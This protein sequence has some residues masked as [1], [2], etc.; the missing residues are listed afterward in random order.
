M[1]TETETDLICRRMVRGAAPAQQNKHLE[2]TWDR[3]S[4]EHQTRARRMGTRRL[5]MTSEKPTVMG[6]RRLA[7]T[8][9]RPTVRWCSWSWNAPPRGYFSTRRCTSNGDGHGHVCSPT[10]A[11]NKS[12]HLHDTERTTTLRRPH[13]SLA[14][15]D[16]GWCCR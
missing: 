6:T 12:F 5:A 14:V 16:L 11:S 13:K 4:V 1:P 7:M 15:A 3:E 2:A 10:A 9:E 8:S